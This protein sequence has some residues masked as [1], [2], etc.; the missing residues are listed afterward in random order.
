MG[1][2]GGRDGWQRR[3]H[4]GIAALA[5]SPASPSSL[6]LPRHSWFAPLGQLSLEVLTL[7]QEGRQQARPVPVQVRSVMSEAQ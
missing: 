6:G 5:T 1:C 7:L 3:S 4:L 2:P